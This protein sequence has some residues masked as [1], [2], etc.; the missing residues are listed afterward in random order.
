MYLTAGQTYLLRL[1]QDHRYRRS[2]MQC[3]HCVWSVGATVAPFI[4]HNFLVD[5]PQEVD[6]DVRVPVTRDPELYPATRDNTTEELYQAQ[7][8]ITNVDLVRIPY[9]VVS[10]IVAASSVLFLINFFV[11]GTSCLDPS[12]ERGR[13]PEPD[14]TVGHSIEYKRIYFRFLVLLFWI[15]FVQIWLDCIP[16]SLVAV[17]VVRGLNWQNER[18]ALITSAYSAFHGL[19]RIIAIPL[20]AIFSPTRMLII[21]MTIV[22]AGYG[23]LLF[24]N[25]H[26]SIPWIAA[27]VSGFGIGSA[28]PSCLLWAEG[29]IE[30]TSAASSVFVTAISVG[31][32]VG[33]ALTGF[34]MGY[35]TYMCFVYV[36]LSAAFILL[37]VNV[38]A[39]FYARRM[40]LQNRSYSKSKPISVK[41]TSEEISTLRRTR[42]QEKSTSSC[43]IDD[44]LGFT[45]SLAWKDNN[46]AFFKVEIQK[47]L[48]PKAIN[49]S[50]LR[51]RNMIVFTFLRPGNP[52]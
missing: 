3:L 40:G 30:I 45:N 1:W 33:P 21:D 43:Q 9:V 46:V 31:A 38:S 2:L 8:P 15:F 7:P 27:S 28:F 16:A 22:T 10:T 20:A 18:G 4:V 51:I 6:D 12:R 19:S 13:R 17:F 11:V 37:I 36:L 29:F 49:R 50:R 5:V 26:H 14:N 23:L 52:F 44:N 34:L 35:F 42:L 41:A 32:M 39:A 48:V 47:N 24:V 25:F